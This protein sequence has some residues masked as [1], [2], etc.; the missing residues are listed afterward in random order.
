MMRPSDIYRGVTG[1]MRDSCSADSAGM[2]DAAGAGGVALRD[3]GGIDRPPRYAVRHALPPAA[4][5]KRWRRLHPG[6]H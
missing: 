2:P 5:P 3:G 1:T 4:P 6:A